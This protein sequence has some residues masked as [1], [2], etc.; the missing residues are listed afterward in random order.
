MES[1]SQNIKGIRN[2]N[3]SESNLI[4]N[5]ME[6]VQYESDD[7][8]P[9]VEDPADKKLLLQKSGDNKNLKMAYPGMKDQGVGKREMASPKG[10]FGDSYEKGQPS[11]QPEPTYNTKDKSFMHRNQI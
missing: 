9:Q 8:S 3:K 10:E 11:W 4:I 1:N 2:D 7:R 5:K 6:A